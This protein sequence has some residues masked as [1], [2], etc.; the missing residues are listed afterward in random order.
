MVGAICQVASDMGLETIAEFVESPA[1]ETR[2]A[3]LGVS[4]VQGHAVGKPKPLSDTMSELTDRMIVEAGE[5][6]C[7]MPA[8]SDDDDRVTPL[9][10]NL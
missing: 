3:S 10:A 4:Y 7:T 1:L 8:I 2:L 9:R 6:T 5:D